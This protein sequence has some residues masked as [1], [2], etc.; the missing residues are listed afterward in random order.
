MVDLVKIRKKA[1]ERLSAVGAQRSG[2]PSAETKDSSAQ[3][4]SEAP[5]PADVS[6][7]KR[8]TSKKTSAPADRPAVQPK[9]AARASIQPAPAAPEVSNA[10]TADSRQP[11]ADTPIQSTKLDRFKEQAGRRRE[12]ADSVG[13]SAAAEAVVDERLEVL[14]FAI[15]G[16]NYAI[17][18][19]RIVEIVP[20]RA[21]TRVPN[22]TESIVGIMSL[23]GTIVTLI[24][25]R[26]RL[27]HAAVEPSG[28]TRIIV[29]EHEGET[30]GFEVDRVFRVIKI[31]ASDVAPH[32]VVHASE[33][34]ESIR[35]VFRHGDS[36]TILLDFA[37]LL[38]GRESPRTG[39]R[40]ALISRP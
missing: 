40:Q 9:V 27:T 30:I 29:L 15:A 32:P 13:R 2:E 26:R 24:D 21:A 35:G 38:G 18:I 23:R 33:A 1:K 22:A 31:A 10:P 16:E 25:V 3:P 17:D 5:K 6:A 14:T 7:E 11:T 8:R 12:N 20:P 36:L 4:P 37:K 34:D 19:E 39:P 28:E